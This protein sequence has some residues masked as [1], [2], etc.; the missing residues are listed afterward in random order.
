[1][2]NEEIITKLLDLPKNIKE[3]KEAV[4]GAQG[5]IS[6]NEKLISEKE[7]ELMGTI[8]T[9]RN[10]DEKLKYTN[11]ESRDNALILKKTADEGYK[12]LVSTKRK[13]ESELLAAKNELDLRLNTFSA[14]KYIADFTASYFR[15]MSK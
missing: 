2:T 7:A 3:A 12:N 5:L 8:L 13:L 10:G 1:M 14:V 6:D 11:K 9:E 4:D 15:I